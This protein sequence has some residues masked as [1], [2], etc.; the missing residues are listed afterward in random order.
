MNLIAPL[1]RKLGYEKRLIRPH[2]KR[3]FDA[4][5]YNRL[6]TNWRA[7]GISL[8]S[9]LAG[10]LPT[11]IARARDLGEN[12]EYFQKFLT[13]LKCNVIGENGMT[14]KNKACDP[15]VF[16]NGDLQPPV[17][18]KLA[19]RLIE[20][21]WAEWCKKENCTTTKNLTWIQVQNLAVEEFGTC[22]E[23][24]WEMVTGAEAKNKFGFALRPIQ[25]DRLYHRHNVNLGNG[26]VVRM[27]VEK[28]KDG[29]TVALWITEADPTD[30]LYTQ[31]N[32]FTA[33]RYPAENFVRPFLMRRI[34]QS[35]GVPWAAAA[36]LRMKMLAGYDVATITAAEIAACKM[37]FLTKTGAGA[38]YQGEDAAGGGKYMD[39]EPGMIEE[40]PVGMEVTP[41]DWNQPSANYEPFTKAAIRGMACGLNVSYPNLAND[42]GEVNFSSGRMARLEE[43]EFW[44]LIQSSLIEDFHEPIFAKWLEM[45]LMA[46]AIGYSMPSGAEVKLPLSKLEKF[47]K[48]YFHGRRW[49]WVDPTK[50]V[51]AK[52][53]ELALGLTSHT[54]ILAELGIDRDELFDEI[55]DDIKA[56]AAR[57][58]E[59]PPVGAEMSQAT[60]ENPEEET[61]P[62]EPAQTNGNG[63]FKLN[64][65]TH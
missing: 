5:R 62:A 34:G 12:N 56:A 29:R 25:I 38:E 55:A 20:S 1:L 49:G 22:G 30:Y 51:A 4:A 35:R 24:L 44:K 36:M 28:D 8:D 32:Q 11:L 2:M 19:N 58:I 60:P 21:A 52:K 39:A 10:D 48:P 9:I 59:L 42:Y 46:G 47:N 26:N 15:P 23:T 18:D 43:T 31:G 7:F 50:E 64:G 54:R 3:S 53:E 57:G 16:R 40:L 37:A 33:K 14:L 63:R 6:T 27:G 61:E 41:V 65:L 13:M 45:S 17:L